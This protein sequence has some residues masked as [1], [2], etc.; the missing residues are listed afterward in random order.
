MKILMVS[1]FLPY[2]LF[3]GGNIRLYNLLKHLS[4]KHQITLIC[5]KR[6]FQT[7]KDLDEVKKFCQKVITVER[8]K[9]W[10][11]GNILKSVFS[12]DPFLVVG[13]TSLEMKEKIKKELIENNFNLIH[14]ETFYV[15]QNLPKTTLP[16]F[17]AEHNI[18]YLV[19]KRYA[20]ESLFWI[21]P[22]IKFDNW[23]LRKK[24]IQSWTLANK[25]IAVSD[26]EK[27]IMK[28]DAIIIP[29]GVDLEE[30]DFQQPKEKMKEKEKKILFIGDFKWIE[31]RNSAKWILEKIWPKINL[32]FNIKLWIVGRNIPQNLKKMRV[33]NIIFDENLLNTK[34]A[35]KKSYILLSPI[36]VGGGTSFKILEAMASGTPVVTTSLGAEG[37]ATDKELVIADSSQ[38]LI[39]KTEELLLNS[40]LYEKIAKN[41]R[42]KIEENFD[43]KNI[44]EK[45]DKAYRE[46]IYD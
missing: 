3:N 34:E 36:K 12:L 9:Q 37:I 43:W 8:K 38:D 26:Q 25:L 2:P 45:L 17:L 42:K 1:S 6:K 35:Y 13:H 19:Y 30:F 46:V 22:L 27:R 7:E 10:S 32:K 15:F 18:E 21:R 5:E 41:A 31:N 14:V 33:K 16:I 11:V 39:D 44:A 40:D 29:N 28:K 20:E 24:E 4:K 23:K